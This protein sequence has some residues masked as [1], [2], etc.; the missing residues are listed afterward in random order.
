MLSRRSGPVISIIDA[1]AVALLA[2]VL[3]FFCLSALSELFHAAVFSPDWYR[4]L[5]VIFAALFGLSTL[6]SVVAIIMDFNASA[7]STVAT[8]LFFTLALLVNPRIQVVLASAWLIT[9]IAVGALA[10]RHRTLYG[11]SWRSYST[12]TIGDSILS[13][14]FL[15]V[16]LVQGKLLSVIALTVGVVVGI[17]FI[18]ICV[19]GMP[20]LGSAERQLVTDT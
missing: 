6:V 13:L 5:I 9:N 17:F 20:S 12:L 7:I 18:I 10:Y 19:I 15:P 3:I 14:V 16:I 4:P 2:L 1:S 11:T 8:P